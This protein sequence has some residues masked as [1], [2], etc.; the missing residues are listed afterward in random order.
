[1]PIKNIHVSDQH[2]FGATRLSN[3]TLGLPA[4]GYVI[5]ARHLGQVLQ[6]ALTQTTIFA[7][8]FPIQL[9]I[10]P[11]LAE[12]ILNLNGQT[13]RLHTRLVVAADGARSTIRQYA[14]LNLEEHDYHQDALIAN[15]TLQ[16]HHQYTAYER[17]TVNGPLALLPLT[18]DD[19]SL[20][21]T[22]NRADTEYLQ[23]MTDRDFLA[24]LQQQFG[25]RLGRF[26]R[27]GQRQT[28]PLCLRHVP[29][30]ACSRVVAIGNAA[31]TLHPIAGQGFNLGLRDVA[32]LAEVVSDA[33]QAGQDIGSMETLKQYVMRQ[34]PDQKRVT[35]ITNGLV[36]LFSNAFPPL[37]TARNLGLLLTDMLPPLKKSLMM[38]MT[39][40]KGYPSRLLRGLPVYK[41]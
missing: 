20:V 7:P 26:M 8:A 21:W 15:V 3:E 24:R 13:H 9:H 34:Q 6:D 22:V 12:V 35:S 17:F 18:D 28:Y 5:R 10:H 37:V 19:C 1:V 23:A 38:Q 4:L 25:W 29:Q 2:Q 30:P 41:P 14:G 11:T 16:Y 33:Q 39:G 27:V 32:H 40:L 31:H 36:Q